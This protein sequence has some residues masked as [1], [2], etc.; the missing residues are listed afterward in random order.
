MAA[1]ENQVK[2]P[3]DRVTDGG[4]YS[5]WCW[6]ANSRKPSL[7]ESAT[8]GAPLPGNEATKQA[9]QIRLSQD[10]GPARQGLASGLS[11]TPHDI[12]EGELETWG[13]GG[14][15]SCFQSPLPS[16]TPAKHVGPTG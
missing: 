11:H 4:E 6:E 2:R 1:R 13:R 5:A 8:W 15:D 10:A 14:L 12:S 9:E 3:Q 16:L 7:E